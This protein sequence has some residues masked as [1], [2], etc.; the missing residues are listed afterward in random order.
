M[1]KNLTAGGIGQNN[2][3]LHG[4]FNTSGVYT[5]TLTVYGMINDDSFTQD[6]QNQTR[7]DLGQNLGKIKLID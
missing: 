2:G 5:V 4:T 7:I 1:H 6:S 3:C